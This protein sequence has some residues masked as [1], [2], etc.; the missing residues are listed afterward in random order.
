MKLTYSYLRTQLRNKGVEVNAQRAPAKED[1]EGDSP[2]GDAPHGDSD[3][4]DSYHG[5]APHGDSPHGD[6][7]HGDSPDF[8]NKPTGYTGDEE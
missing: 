8:L 7:L 5:D 2:H 6:S 1:A 3:H 4:G